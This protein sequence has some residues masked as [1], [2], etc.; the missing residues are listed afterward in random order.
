VIELPPAPEGGWACELTAL[1]EKVMQSHAQGGALT[2][3]L[4][5]FSADNRITTAEA[6]Q[7]VA[8]ASAE[9]EVLLRF[10]R[11]AERAARKDSGLGA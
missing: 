3:A 6:E 1:K 10:I 7:L 11:N 9:V 4:M 8:L 2:A 5:S